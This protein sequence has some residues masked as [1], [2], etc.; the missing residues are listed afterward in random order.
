[1]FKVCLVV[2]QTRL[3]FPLSTSKSGNVLDLVHLDVWEPYRI[4]S[5][6]RFRYFSTMVDDCSRMTIIFAQIKGRCDNNIKKFFIDGQNS[7]F[8]YREAV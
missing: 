2:K 6:I 4:T 7:K 8:L 1:M 3:F 5:H